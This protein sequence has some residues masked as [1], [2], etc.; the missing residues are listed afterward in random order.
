MQYYFSRT[1]NLQSH[2]PLW[3]IKGTVGFTLKKKSLYL[4]LEN[5]RGYWGRRLA[6]GECWG[7]GAT[8]Q[9]VTLKEDVGSI[10]K[11]RG[12]RKVVV[13]LHYINI[14]KIYIQTYI[15]TLRMLFPSTYL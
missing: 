4:V 7:R 15:K 3:E 1:N 10:D 5:E 11:Q 8:V 9:L 14:I 2:P 6:E 13:L 12:S